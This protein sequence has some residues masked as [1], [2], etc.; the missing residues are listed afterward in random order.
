VETA[1]I[2]GL[3]A[4]KAVT[5][6]NTRLGKNKQVNV[7]VLLVLRREKRNVRLSFMRSHV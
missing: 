7:D 6:K 4:D 3:F 1:L 5:S 2:G